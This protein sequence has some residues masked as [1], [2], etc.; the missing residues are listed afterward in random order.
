MNRCRDTFVLVVMN[1]VILGVI[2]ELLRTTAG[3]SEPEAG[4]SAAV[5]LATEYNLPPPAIETCEERLAALEVTFEASR[6]PLHDSPSGWFQC[7]AAQVVRYKRGPDQIRYSTSPKMT[8]QM[9]LA[10][11][12]FERIVQEEAERHFGKS[13]VKIRQRG[14]YNCREIKAYP[15]WV[16]QHSFANALDVSEFTL[17]GGKVIT[18][19]DHYGREE[20]AP[21]KDESR[22]LRAVAHRLYD[23][24]VFSSVLT[25]RFDR[26]H[27]N[28]FHFDMASFRTDGTR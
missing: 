9:A 13:V 24:D 10:L 1:G 27:R 3:D 25:P 21:D 14:T 23:E 2:L 8:C 17:K 20:V 11:P 5:P 26:A 22:F 12:Q 16:S 6:I 7:G 15:G 19:E 18:V 4:A 28:H